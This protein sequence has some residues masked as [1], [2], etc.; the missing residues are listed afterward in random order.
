MKP[1]SLGKQIM[2]GGSVSFFKEPVLGEQRKWRYFAFSLQEGCFPHVKHGLLSLH[3]ALRKWR[4]CL[5]KELKTIYPKQFCNMVCGKR[6][7]KVTVSL[8]SAASGLLC[9][10]TFLNPSLFSRSLISISQCFPACDS[11]SLKTHHQH[12]F[13][14]FLGFFYFSCQL[15]ALLF[16]SNTI[17]ESCLSFLHRATLM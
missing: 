2:V 5:W 14:F 13:S 12:H 8:P 4:S 9:N 1:Y 7:G 10:L 3:Q 15:G 16:I 11:L 6:G 17:F